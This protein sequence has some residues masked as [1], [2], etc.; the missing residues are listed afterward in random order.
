MLHTSMEVTQ[1]G[2]DLKSMDCGSPENNPSWQLPATAIRQLGSRRSGSRAGPGTQSGV[3]AP[4]PRAK[5]N[6]WQIKAW[7]L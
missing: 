1:T 3:L 5:P 2:S 6:P 7:A 4:S